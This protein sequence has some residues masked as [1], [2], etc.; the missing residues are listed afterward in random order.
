MALINKVDISTIDLGLI[1]KEIL[2]EIYDFVSRREFQL[3]L[4]DLYS[5][6]VEERANFV[7]TVLLN[8]EILKKGGVIAPDGLV[9]QRSVFGDGRPT[10]FCVSKLLPERYWHYWKKLTITFDN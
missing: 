9:I 6:P 1:M 7:E 5:L 8:K 2:Q 10:L 4:R 3:V